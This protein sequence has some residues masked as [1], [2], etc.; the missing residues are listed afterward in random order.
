MKP[1]WKFR[2]L[3]LLIVLLV[4]TVSITDFATE[5]LRPAPSAGAGAE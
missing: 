1:I 4:G 5:R 2:L 3:A